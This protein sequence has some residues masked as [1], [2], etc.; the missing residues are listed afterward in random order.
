MNEYYFYGLKAGRDSA[1]PHDRQKFM[2]AKQQLQALLSNNQ[3]RIHPPDLDRTLTDVK[4]EINSLFLFE[5]APES[6]ETSISFLNPIFQERYESLL[7]R[8]NDLSEQST[9][10]VSADRVRNKAIAINLIYAST[11][12]F[13]ISLSV[14]IARLI[15]LRKSVLLPIQTLIE[16]IQSVKQ[17]DLSVRSSI[18]R[19]DEIGIMSQTINETISELEQRRVERIRI[20]G[21]IAHDL[22]NPLAAV[23][24]SCELLLRKGPE[25]SVDSAIGFAKTIY[26]QVNRIT[27]MVEDLLKAASAVNPGFSIQVTLANL[28]RVTKEIVELFKT[29]YPE[30]KY[31]F[32]EKDRIP[33]IFVDQDRMA[34]ALTN[35][36]S[37]ATKYSEP[38]TEIEVEVGS[39]SSLVYL[40]VRDRGIG[41]PEDKIESVFQPFTRLESGQK[42]SPGLGLGLATVKGIVKAHSGNISARHRLGGGTVF[43]IELP[44]VQGSVERS[45]DEATY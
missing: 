43:R 25:L 32:I 12:M 41:I 7:D 14:A 16:T 3:P 35:L 38:G 18:R 40:E 13:L 42:M 26:S 20:I 31:I 2:R 6:H 10:I 1:T 29:S 17:G 21:A 44:K 39:E 15:S 34:Q 19:N 4:Q 27:R 30:R 11:G 45:S 22:K 5:P 8:L 9:A 33:E 23:G 36:L 24:L 37:N 28:T